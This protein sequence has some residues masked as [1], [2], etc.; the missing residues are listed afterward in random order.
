M[1]KSFAVGDLVTYPG[2][3]GIGTVGEVMES[4]ARIDFFASVAEPV[5]RSTRVPLTHCSPAWLST[6]TR[7]YW[8]NPDTGR[9]L[10]GRVTGRAGTRYFVA[11]P[12]HRFD[13]PIPQ[14]QLRVRW[15]GGRTD[16]AAVLGVGAHESGYFRNTR[17]PFLEGLIAQRGA[18]AS[19]ASFLSSAVE[20]YPHQVDA[21]LTI[22]SDP[23]QRYLLADEVGLG[24]TVEAGYVVRQ[25]LI[26]NPGARVIVLT[27]E[28]LRRQWAE[29]M[30]SKFFIDDFRDASVKFRSH[31]NP[32]SWVDYCGWDLLV[33][34]EAHR[35]TQVETPSEGA[36]PQ[37]R[38]LAHSVKKLLLISATPTTSHYKT[39][40]GL[41][42]LLD[43]K[44]YSWDDVDRFEKMYE[45]RRALANSVY[46]LDAQYP[47]YLAMSIDEIRDLLVASDPQFEKLGARILGLVGEDYE[48][49]EGVT[50][51]ELEKR[52]EELRAHVSETYRLHR[53]VIRHRRVNVLEEQSDAEFPSYEVRGRQ[54][55]AVLALDSEV[56]DAAENGVLDWCYQV[57]D[58]LSETA[59]GD[60]EEY[61]AVLRILVS[62]SGVVLDDLLE[63]LRWRVRADQ[64]AADRACLSSEEQR[65]LRSAPILPFEPQLLADLESQYTTELCEK[66]LSCLFRS[67]RDV[68]PK[69][70][71]AVIFCGPGRLGP[72]LAGHL[73]KH[74]PTI[75]LG[76]HTSHLTSEDAHEAV[77]AWAAPFESRGPT[78]LLAVDG[79]GEDGLNLQLAEAAFHL[80]M[81]WSPNQLEQRLG[82][83]DRY[84]SIDAVGQS[85]PA[86]QYRLTSM[87]GDVSFGDTWAELLVE[88][89]G[90][91][92]ESVSTL[93]DAIADSIGDVWAHG[94]QRGPAGLHTRTETVRAAL[95]EAREEIEKMDL[96]ESIHHPTTRE[97]SVALALNRF[98][99]K[100]REWE[101]AMSGFT[102]EA[103]GGIRLRSRPGKGTQVFDIPGSRPLVDPR[104]WQRK[105]TRLPPPSVEGAFNRSAALKQAGTRLF[106][107][108]NPLTDA[109]ADWAWDDDRGQATAFSRPHVHL[110]DGADPYFGFDYLVEADIA[111]ALSL[112]TKHAEAE[113]ALRR[114]A[115]QL[116][117]PFTVRVWI[118]AFNGKPVVADA[119][120]QWL[121]QPYDKVRLRDRNYSGERLRN[122]FE[123]FGGS[124]EYQA[125][126]TAAEQASRAHMAAVT[127][128]RTLCDEARA[129]AEQR[130]AIA[131]AQAR[132][133]SAAG[134]LVGDLESYL[135][136]TAVTDALVN[137]LSNPATRLIAA[138]CLV[139]VP[140]VFRVR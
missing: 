10:P 70:R 90:L 100:W 110:K 102:S 50:E 15:D 134:H 127:D 89:Y 44:I 22:L 29:E 118:H 84:R 94:L 124:D 38:V 18:S 138:V 30:L 109:L 77:R 121:D 107:S 56:H 133:R 86:D 8:R 60:Y 91:F 1:K 80:R 45:R 9:W 123:I 82:R 137:G 93:Q 128:L 35:L 113:Q 71:R 117:T 69:Y 17:L 33:V 114:K 125:A 112:A 105:V 98:E 75:M 36:Y 67:L 43:P 130:V 24:K 88:G 95:T 53:R 99:V 135:V 20:I 46:S 49:R 28:S 14:S 52:V 132:A 103:E 129:S 92:R 106:R 126:T 23:V 31:E 54:E 19:S 2:S 41:L 63:A 68:L 39:H 32:E 131:R 101:A 5:A 79:S 116:L 47:V 26:D 81:P 85:R 40:L 96:L 78:R 74:F 6:E 122:L 140:G 4:Q 3:P 61:G 16:P 65:T 97:T 12:N 108:G 34:D 57:T 59:S 139:R 72:L 120:R 87:Q 136:D 62:R 42:H 25:T 66:A 73:R 7:V 48:L 111:P 83:L 27:P 104:H 51:A 21:A 11:F 55:P 58:H 115:D 13:F 37:L 64:R 119:Q 76:E